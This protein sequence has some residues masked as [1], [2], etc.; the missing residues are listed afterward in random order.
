MKWCL[1]FRTWITGVLFTLRITPPLSL[2]KFWQ[3]SLS[4]KIY[5][6]FFR[7]NGGKPKR[8]LLSW[9]GGTNG[10]SLSLISSGWKPQGCGDLIWTGSHLYARFISVKLMWPVDTVTGSYLKGW[11]VAW[12]VSK[13]QLFVS[14]TTRTQPHYCAAVGNFW[15]VY[16]MFTRAGHRLYRDI[17]KHIHFR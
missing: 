15:M 4:D 3:L 7:L 11:R 14:I 5:L 10:P 9:R 13:V 2:G 12:P 8:C 6:G 17:V 16:C 1:L